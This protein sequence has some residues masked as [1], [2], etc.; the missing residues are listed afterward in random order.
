A[1]LPA[2]DA[3]RLLLQPGLGAALGL[4]RRS[5]RVSVGATPPAAARALPGWLPLVVVPIVAGAY[6]AAEVALAGKLG[7]SLDDGWTYLAFARSFAEGEPFTYPGHEGPVAAVTAP[8][9]CLLLAASFAIAG[10]TVVVAKLA[11]LL[12]AL[13]AVLGSW[14]LARTATGDAQLAWLVAL[15]VGSSAR[16]LWGALSG[17]EVALATGLT[18]LGL[19]L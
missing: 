2:Q 18:S 19:A 3:A 1:R 7:P 10:P 12:T 17:M 4:R 14:R 11:G 16:L 15:L 8:L 6:L 9:W 5:A 13:I